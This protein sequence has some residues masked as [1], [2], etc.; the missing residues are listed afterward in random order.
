M[1]GMGAARKKL[2]ETLHCNSN[3]KKRINK[4][5]KNTLNDKQGLTP[6]FRPWHVTRLPGGVAVRAALCR[7]ETG[8]T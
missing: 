8:K 4:C 5:A 3:L 2:K 7:L 6:R 1:G